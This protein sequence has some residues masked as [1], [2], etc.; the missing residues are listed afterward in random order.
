MKPGEIPFRVIR[1][2][3]WISAT[4]SELRYVS[5]VD[6]AL[7]KRATAA[8]LREDLERLGWVRDERTCRWVPPGVKP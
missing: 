6:L 8:A 4:L 2:T 7:Q 3:G 1:E 5:D